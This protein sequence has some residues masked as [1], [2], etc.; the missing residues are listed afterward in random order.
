MGTRETLRI[1][2]PTPTFSYFLS[3]CTGR[4]PWSVRGPHA[5]LAL[6]TGPTGNSAPGGGVRTTTTSCSTQ[7]LEGP[8]GAGGPLRGGAPRG[9]R[10]APLP[11]AASRAPP[12]PPSRLPRAPELRPAPNVHGACVEPSGHGFLF[13]VYTNARGQGEGEGCCVSSNIY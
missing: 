13:P 7:P 1:R 11:P 4:P 9:A 6:P 10:G 5:L 3:P 12:P 8:E 2:F